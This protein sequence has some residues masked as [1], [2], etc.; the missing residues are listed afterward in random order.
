MGMSNVEMLSEEELNLLRE[1]IEDC[2]FKEVALA[3]L[4]AYKDRINES[5]A[6]T[7]REVAE[8]KKKFGYWVSGDEE[9]D[10]EFQLALDLARI[11]VIKGNTC[12]DRED[13]RLAKKIAK[14]NPSLVG[15]NTFDY[16]RQY[17]LFLSE[18]AR[19]MREFG[20][21]ELAR[22]D[23]LPGQIALS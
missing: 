10:R 1:K 19:A 23:E 16:F 7:L 8:K 15:L 9:Y 4:D 12:D 14:E 6:A 2:I 22:Q 21:I 5:E 17:C 11:K 13:Y 18:Q 20:L 3:I